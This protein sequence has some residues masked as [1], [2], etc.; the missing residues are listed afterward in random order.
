M[1]INKRMRTTTTKS[2]SEFMKKG[3]WR[4]GPKLNEWMN[5]L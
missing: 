3:M 2:S 1:D 4:L 5:V